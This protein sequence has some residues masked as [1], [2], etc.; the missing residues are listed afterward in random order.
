MWSMIALQFLKVRVSPQTKVR[1]HGAALDKAVATLVSVPVRA[2][3]RNLAPL[4]KAELLA[5]RQTVSGLST[6]GRHLNQLAKLAQQG[7]RV[8][9]APNDF[10]AM[11]KMVA[12][13]LAP[14]RAAPPNT[15]PTAHIEIE[16]AEGVRNVAS[17]ISST[18]I[19]EHIGRQQRIL[20]A[21]GGGAST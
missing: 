17:N 13:H 1:V 2:H 4:P 6:I 20:S 14:K 18:N 19:D 16:L 12:V 7:N 5:L 9:S 8:G 15:D 11:L 10:G 21:N 3:L